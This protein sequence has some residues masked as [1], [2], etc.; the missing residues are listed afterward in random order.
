MD[1]LHI[2]NQFFTPV[3]S[4]GEFVCFSLFY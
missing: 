2:I 1:I 3:P 4:V